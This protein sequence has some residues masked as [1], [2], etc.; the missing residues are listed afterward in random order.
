MRIKAFELDEPVPALNEPHVIA[1]LK[2]WID[3]GSVGRL[4]LKWLEDSL[5]V[6]DLA[7]LA[8]PGDFFDFSR[9]RPTSFLSGGRRRM[10]VPN[11]Y[12]TY[13]KRESGHDFIFIHMLEPHGHGELYVD[14]VLQLMQHFG[15][16]RY[17]IAGSMH[18][19]VPHTRP[20]I[21]T[22][23]AIGKGAHAELE[24]NN[25][26][27]IE[28]QGPTSICFLISQR[29]PDMGIDTLS[30]IAH[31]PQYTQ[32]DEDFIGTVRIMK[33]LS[34]MYG[35][36][37]NESY[38][39]KAEQQLEQIDTA[40][41]K[42]PQLKTIVKQLENHYDTRSGRQEEKD[43]TELSPEVEKFL[44]EMDRRFREG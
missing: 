9:H 44:S 43:T 12:V 23:E 38:I 21:V 36:P 15:A 5:G 16:R 6:K 3:G 22:G 30:L 8:R 14:S 2:P 11:T 32:M 34:S 26:E 41:E 27:S 7:K 20:M 13:G 19:Y 33:I 40:L 29:A 18:D 25:I 39:S 42:N 35:I 24:A 10:T 31:L 4:T 28:Y 37:V 17:I 1:V